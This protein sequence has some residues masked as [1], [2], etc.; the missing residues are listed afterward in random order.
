VC[1]THLRGSEVDGTVFTFVRKPT[2]PFTPPENPH[3]P[4]IMVGAGTG[5]APF[6]GFLQERAAL[7][8]RGV[9]IAESLLFFG[10]RTPD[11]DF[12]YADELRAFER[13][14][15]VKLCTAFSRVAD[16]RRYVQQAIVDEA[17]EV[18]RLL[19]QDAHVYVCGNANTMAP[20]VRAAFMEV[21]GGSAD[22]ADGETWLAGMRAEHRYLEDIWGESAV[23]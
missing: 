10:C 7:K 22:S 11:Q 19:D 12:L 4:M 18:R 23:G 13:D 17:D 2:I 9:P 16:N 20:A 1:S 14:G 6:R 5:M 15:V 8:R 3:I 21:H